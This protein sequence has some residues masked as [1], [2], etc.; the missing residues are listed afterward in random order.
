M[1]L[2]RDI[3]D[4]L[5]REG[6]ADR[7]CGFDFPQM[8]QRDVIMSGAIADAVA[9]AVE[10]R[11]RH[12]HEVGNELGGGRRRLQNAKRSE[13][14]PVAGRPGT[15]HQRLAARGDRR[16]RQLRAKGRERSH[17]RRRID[18]AADRR[19]AGDDSA[20][21][22]LDGAARVWQWLRPRQRAAPRSTH[23]AARARRCGDRLLMGWM[24]CGFVTQIVMPGLV[25]GIQSLSLAR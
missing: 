13:Y 10:R 9:G 8:R 5:H 7:G 11:Q 22:D 4:F 15:K 12:Q 14:Q 25:P 19:V 2:H 16:Q 23:R 1:R 6:K 20:G 21:F 17:Q 18:L 3:L 24:T